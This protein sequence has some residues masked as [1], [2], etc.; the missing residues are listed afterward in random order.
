MIRSLCFFF[1]SIACPPGFLSA[2]DYSYINYGIK[3]GLAGST[4]YCMVQDKDG[5]LWFGTETG[6]SRYDGTH[7]Q[8]FYTGSGL[9][10]NEIIKLFVDSKNRVWIVPFSNSIA[11][12]RNGKIH[13][14]QNDSLLRKLKI[15]SEVISVLEDGAGN[16]LI[17]ETS[18]AHI[19][20]TSG[21]V[22]EVA[23]FG[24]SPFEILQ[25]GI[26]GQSGY[27][28]LINSKKKSMVADL[29]GDSLLPVRILDIHAPGSYNS[30]YISPNLEIFVQKDSLIF[31]NPVDGKNFRLPFP[32]G[33]MSVSVINDS[34]VAINA[35]RS[36]MLVNIRQKKVM[37]DC[38]EGQTVNAVLEDTEGDLWFS[39]LGKGVYRLGT[40]EVRNYVFRNHN[41][42][43]PVFSIREFDST[44]YVGTD[45]FFLW[46]FDPRRKHM[47]SQQIF[48]RFSRGR[49]TAMV[50]SRTGGMVIGTD[51]GLFRLKSFGEKATAFWLSGAVKSL[52]LLN[53][54]LL[55]DCS[56]LNAWE[57]P[58]K[59]PRVKNVVWNMRSTCG[60]R[61][62]GV[63][64]IGTLNG[65]FAIGGDRKTVFLGDR[66]KV[67]GARIADLRE[68]PDG[69]LWV[70]T[71]GAGLAGYKDGKLLTLITEDKGLT[72]NICRNIFISPGI[73]WVGTDKGLNKITISNSGTSITRITSADG[74]S[75]D[76]VNA[77][78]VEG[79]TVFVGT[80]EGISSFDE[81]Q[82]SQRSGCRL[83][84]TGISI[85]G[86]DWPADTTGFTV[87]HPDNDILLR[88]VGIS[89]K[90]GGEI[91]YQYR[92]AGLDPGWKST[93]E[94][95]LHYPSLPSGVYELQL[96][97]INK[98]GVRSKPLH[99]RFVIDRLIWERPWFRILLVLLLIGGVWAVL[100]FRVS[101]V[102]KKETEKTRVAAR[103]SEL[104]QM[105]LR[106]QMNP[107]FIFN[108]LNSIQQYVMDK[109]VRGANEF[110]T[111][112]SR[113]V[114]QTL[115]I[116]ARPRIS[117]AEEIQYI[118]TYLELEKTRYENKFA[119]EVSI[120]DEIDRQDMHIPP[121]ILQPYI[122]NAIR[123]GIGHRQ[124]ELGRIKIR[125]ETDGGSDGQHRKNGWSNGEGYLV[126]I[127]KDNGVGRQQAGLFKG[128]NPIHYQSQGMGLTAKR[129]EMLNKT[130]KSPIL[131]R[132][133]DLEDT[134]GQPSGTR[135]VIR[136]PLEN[137]SA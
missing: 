19:L 9:P 36:T 83:Q 52:S 35:S 82:M 61:K 137:M 98:F 74:L 79:H 107:H 91:N 15:R 109:D 49:L 72:S 106:S 44:L 84:V 115:D 24:T 105:A 131:I 13:N 116:S 111:N 112:F 11:Y 12:Y 117:L 28:L 18:C 73:I 118:S 5:F 121:L 57:I 29:R 78:Y 71:D 89:F 68:A 129:V 8:N 122:E 23:A 6:L 41:A 75:A 120:A 62:D 31:L 39:T 130:S 67:F 14:Q 7:F 17:A 100:H 132:I 95:S 16:I 4:V 104:E 32:K 96:F 63:Y 92:L 34:S 86:K 47:R 90:S 102:R 97:A 124:D 126:C 64:Y 99:I 46:A 37:T 26:N 58:L 56:S 22:S 128:R 60:C 3:D 66:Y 70:A 42:V 54:S 93:R 53:D 125:M 27:R 114:R 81:R 113:L 134:N 101:R 21:E 51:A 103:M 2:Q 85:A 136:F 30:S 59:E 127:I 40:T 135:V 88:F 80:S 33:F 43:L 55:L 50:R 10:D 48:D 108:C 65:L 25:A 110:I 20:H 123:H 1:L 69:T 45:H 76:I 119:Y 38:M 87:P 94:T 77:V 133:E